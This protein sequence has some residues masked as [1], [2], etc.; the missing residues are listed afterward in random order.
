MYPTS[1]PIVHD[2]TKY[3]HCFDVL[4]NHVCDLLST[5]VFLTGNLDRI[6]CLA[7]HLL[8]LVQ[9]DCTLL[10]EYFAVLLFLTSAF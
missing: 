10:P 2:V 9:R 8:V 4:L 3:L 6:R 7:L 5:E 1:N